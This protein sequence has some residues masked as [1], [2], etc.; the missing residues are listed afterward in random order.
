MLLSLIRK[1][2]PGFISFLCSL[3]ICFQTF[4]QEKQPSGVT[5]TVQVEW[6]QA[7][8]DGF[9]EALN[10]RVAK[11][12]ILKGKGKIKGR[13]FQFST[14]AAVCIKIILDSINNNPGPG[15]TLV[16]IQTKQNPFSFFLRDVTDKF[17][18]YIKEYE[19][20]VLSSGDNRSFSDVQAHIHSL[21]LSTKQQQIENEPE[22]SFAAVEKKVRNQ[23]VPTWL[24]I[25]RDFRIFQVAEPFVDQPMEA[26]VITPQLAA[27]GVKLP[28]MKNNNAAYL[29][30]TGRGQGV[31]LN[32]KRSLEEGV[33]PILHSTT[34]DENLSYHSTSFVA[35]E[36]STLHNGQ[37]A[38]T[39][40]LVADNY[41][42]GH[43]FTD[44]QQTLLKIKLQ[45]AFNEPEETVFYFRSVAEN[46]SHAPA[47]AWFKTPKPGNGWYEQYDY[48]FNNQTG[49]SAYS[50]DKVFCISTLNGNPLP[51]EEI[52]VLLQP[53]EKAVFEFF[54]PHSPVS[55]IRAKAL[56]QQ[57]FNTK[58][59][60]CISFWKSKLAQSAEIYVPEQRV[61]NMI[62]AGLLHLD[63][64]TYGK[65]PDSTLAPCIGVYSPIGTES[66]PIIQFYTS[67]GWNDIAKRSLNY[68]LDKQH[69]DGMIQNFGGYMVE[70]GAALWTMG[71]YYRYTHD[72]DWVI[73]NKEKLIKSC[74]FLFAWRERNKKENLRGKGYG[75]IDGKVAD[76]EDQFHQFM[77][78]GYGYLGCIRVAEMLAD[79]DAV[80]SARIKKESTLWKEDIRVSF[81]SAMALAPVVPSGDGAWVSSVSPWPEMTGPR[82]LFI[83]PE[84]F[85]SHGTF[86]TADAL[87]GPLYLVFCEVLEPHEQ[88]AG[89]MLN[90]HR[91]MFY[92]N[93][94]AFSQP[95]Y[96]RHNWMQ[97]KLGMVK[98]FLKT[99]YN[100]FAALADRETFTFWEHVFHVSVH[101]THEEA[102]FLMETRWMLYLEEGTTLKL[103]NTIPRN[104]ME[105]GKHIE[106][107]NVSSY[108]GPL[109][110][111]VQSSV[112]AGFIKATI[113]C[114]TS[115][116]LKDVIIRLPHPQG[117]KAVKVTGG[118]Y[119]AVT[120]SV[121]IAAFKGIAN[122]R[123]EF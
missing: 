25:S 80:Q 112:N 108:F 69:M 100:A 55:A 101:K 15:S 97:A 76:P 52:A 45:T 62:K 103:L 16:S 19:V 88:A 66:A 92:Q 90:Y 84:K 89:M 64:V 54:L 18:I 2:L 49:F 32:T 119:N 41:S 56:S 31:A 29:Y 8:L 10:G 33:L 86:T 98:P 35:L 115:R 57:S 53:G 94:V 114:D 123:L 79:I 13:H 20:A 6:K 5:D 120:E 39:D 7:P 85:F 1:S 105:E 81:F 113:T 118:I 110:V 61:N 75:M 65:E 50:T 40:Y 14:S 77:L 122:V 93:N 117:K 47:Y 28:E 87:L 26:N 74:N 96:S 44:E 121:T 68:F 109:N 59:Q 67:M 36:K 102:W 17:P 111:S 82:A 21:A 12:E 42:H 73:K 4:S 46:T 72:K 99:Y 11:I 107:K 38:G 106:L 83:K 37:Q 63:L 24:G 34:V 27:S 116:S 23:H 70:T 71:E 95:Y 22:E 58:L 78:N 3:T 104:W 51:N 60:E 91:E 30:N 48:T 43:M 9:I